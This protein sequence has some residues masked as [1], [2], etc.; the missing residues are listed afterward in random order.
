MAPRTT[1][2]YNKNTRYAVTTRTPIEFP[3][4]DQTVRV[5]GTHVYA[6]GYHKSNDETS[7]S[8]A[9]HQTLQR[10]KTSIR[11]HYCHILISKGLFLFVPE[12]KPIDIPL[13]FSKMKICLQHSTTYH[14]TILETKRDPE[15]YQDINVLLSLG[16]GENPQINLLGQV[17]TPNN[18]SHETMNTYLEHSSHSKSM[19]FH[20]RM[21]Y[22]R[23][24]SMMIHLKDQIILFQTTYT[25][26]PHL[27]RSTITCW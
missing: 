25:T 23:Y 2:L 18:H 1:I 12:I 19:F 20:Q 27:I 4:G 5:R 6:G 22:H 16:L 13:F 21:F 10:K 8:L 15:P 3:N 11:I 14:W 26:S 7:Y 9:T 24:N 17:I